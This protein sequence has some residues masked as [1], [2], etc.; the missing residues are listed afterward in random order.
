VPATNK[1]LSFGTSAALA[2]GMQKTRIIAAQD[3]GRQL[4]WRDIERE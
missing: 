3:Q 4:R 1:S 2:I